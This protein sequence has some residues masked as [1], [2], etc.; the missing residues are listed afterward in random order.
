VLSEFLAK[1][2]YQRQLICFVD[3]SQLAKNR[4]KVAT[5]LNARVT[6]NTVLQDMMRNLLKKVDHFY[7]LTGKRISVAPMSK[8][9]DFRVPPSHPRERILYVGHPL[10]GMEP[11]HI[12]MADFHLYLFEKKFAEIIS[13][14]MHLGAKTIRVERKTGWGRD[15]AG[16]MSVGIPAAGPASGDLLF[17]VEFAGTDNPKLPGVRLWFRNEPSWQQ[18]A[19]G[20]LEFGQKQ[21]S[22][23]LSNQEDYGVTQTL[24][25]NAVK[26]GFELG[27]NFREHQ[28]TV[29][30]VSG[31]F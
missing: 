1:P 7:E 30:I 17:K 3:D 26:A 16:L 14:L 28:A 18:V 13:I 12:P 19:R 5:L 2:Y 25:T 10:E 22:V 31:E 21:Y 15:L 4:E 23:T 11:V 9:E 24:M 20:R 6:A 27:G 29:W 8:K